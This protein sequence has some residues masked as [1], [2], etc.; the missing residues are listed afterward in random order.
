MKP[1]FAKLTF[2]I[3][4]L[5][6]IVY[7]NSKLTTVKSIE[8]YNKLDKNILKLLF[9]NN[10]ADV[11]MPQLDELCRK[12]FIKISIISYN[13]DISDDL[14]VDSNTKLELPEGHSKAG[15]YFIGKHTA[16]FEN[17]NP[18]VEDLI[19]FIH[20][21]LERE[22]SNVDKAYI[23][24][25]SNRF[26]FSFAKP[27]HFIGYEQENLSL[28]LLNL[29]L[30]NIEVDDYVKQTRKQF[31]PN[32]GSRLLLY[33]YNKENPSYKTDI[34]LLKSNLHFDY[35]L[36]TTDQELIKLFTPNKLI[37][38][39]LVLHSSTNNK[40]SFSTAGVY[41]F[42]EF[43]R[44]GV[45]FETFDITEE[46]L[47]TTTSR[48]YEA[49]LGKLNYNSDKRIKD[50]ETTA[51]LLCEKPFNLEF[52]NACDIGKIAMNQRGKVQFIVFDEM[53]GLLSQNL[54]QAYQ[55]LLSNTYVPFNPR[56][57]NKYISYYLNLFGITSQDLPALLV[58]RAD[59]D[60]I[61]RY[62]HKLNS[63]VTAT[64]LLVKV[65]DN[66]E[67]YFKSEIPSIRD[68]NE[69]TLNLHLSNLYNTEEG[70]RLA[71]AKKWK[72][73]DFQAN[74]ISIGEHISRVSIFVGHL[75]RELVFSVF[76]IERLVGT[77]L[78]TISDYPLL[79]ENN[80]K[81]RETIHPA[82][83]SDNLNTFSK[84]SKPIL[85]IISFC[86]RNF[87]DCSKLKSLLTYFK[88]NFITK[89]LRYMLLKN[90][91]LLKTID[92]DYEFNLIK[93][94]DFNP[95]I[96][97]SEGFDISSLP[98]VFIVNYH[99]YVKKGGK[100]KGGSNHSKNILSLIKSLDPNLILHQLNTMGTNFFK[101]VLKTLHKDDIDLETKNI[102]KKLT[103]YKVVNSYVRTYLHFLDKE[104]LD[105]DLNEDIIENDNIT[106]LPSKKKKYKQEEKRELNLDADQLEDGDYNDLPEDYNKEEIFGSNTLK[107][108][109]EEKSL[110]MLK[111]LESLI[112]QIHLLKV[113]IRTH[114]INELG[115]LE[116]MEY[117]AGKRDLRKN[118]FDVL[119]D[120]E[121]D[122][123]SIQ[124]N[125]TEYYWTKDDVMLEII[126]K[127]YN[128]RENVRQSNLN[129]N[130]LEKQIMNCFDNVELD[131]GKF[132]KE[133]YKDFN[134]N[135]QTKED[136]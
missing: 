20:D 131:F 62:K 15:I 27:N 111:L 107:E 30:Q 86:G 133:L 99:N 58:T 109:E 130:R 59:G 102:Q 73:S 92:L 34:P 7:N 25:L 19:S 13:N 82:F 77:N 68:K 12:H 36:F 44:G 84:E 48:Y 24:S 60:K 22:F 65:E 54:E 38:I 28:Q 43:P 32:H 132:I 63:K 47:D 31:Y 26:Y 104:N 125:K 81:N 52:E 136:L 100:L 108:D 51:L 37:V 128:Y 29:K 98:A 56:F 101:E 95:L 79:K 76:G 122:E 115:A 112:R 74:K 72:N 90:R 83:K 91:D 135:E 61:L 53:S 21:Q 40:N 85:T 39:N 6:L 17:R 45:D 46:E 35:L 71:D 57:E 123:E 23:Q 75:I 4:F 105:L 116:T 94:V 5:T 8:E 110:A 3:F 93:I 129:K 113:R 134:L 10:K 50:G 64:E 88:L 1:K 124:L 121:F 114:V 9:I 55:A 18:T 96:N 117:E 41:M 16:E 127:E 33:L 14:D 49:A 70:F 118:P 42:N 2:L 67:R 69:H 89:K 87:K 120:E 106:S 126:G 80:E 97:D 66:K 103:D 119:S 78:N 11:L